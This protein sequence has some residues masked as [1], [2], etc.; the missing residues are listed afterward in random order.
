MRTP[1]PSVPALFAPA[2]AGLALAVAAC[3]GD[4]SPEPT[5]TILMA[6]PDTLHPTDDARN[7][8]S[9]TIAYTD[10]DGDLGRGIA[11]V[12]DCR[13]D[14]LLTELPLP[15]IASDEAVEE[16]IA[17]T[18]ELTLRV[19]DIGEVAPAAAA[20]AACADLG[21]ATPA[22]G[23]AIFCVVLVDRGG[24]VGD[25]DCTAAVAIATP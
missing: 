8:L 11:R 17:I 4:P 21:V 16:G 24:H 7:D 3:A 14:R 1:S 2:L 12:H 18:G 19:N 23:E 13:A 20:P 22:A 15:A 6:A 10:G 5:A 9:I 25:G